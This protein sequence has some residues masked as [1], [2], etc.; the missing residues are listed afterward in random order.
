M[1][2]NLEKKTKPEGM[3]RKEFFIKAGKTAIPSLAILGLS[4]PCFGEENN[5]N[6]NNNNLFDIPKKVVPTTYDGMFE[7]IKNYLMEHKDTYNNFGESPHYQIGYFS[8]D[9]SWFF[10]G[11]TNWSEEGTIRYNFR[12]NCDGRFN[13]T[14]DTFE[15]IKRR[16]EQPAK[17]VN[18]LI[19]KHDRDKGLIIEK[20]T[21]IGRDLIETFELSDE[22]QVNRMSKINQRIKEMF[23]GVCGYL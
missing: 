10:I 20:R 11:Q 22:E 23:Q 17:D 12:D 19:Y 9:P 7:F 8:R 2:N 13:N 4:L 1:E 5:S 16:H 3:S 15:V 18:S 6:N 21:L 14:K